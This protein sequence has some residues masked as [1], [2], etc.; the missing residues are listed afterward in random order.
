MKAVIAVLAMAFGGGGAL[1]GEAPSRV[2]GE[3]L[4]QPG[5]LP[6]GDRFVL[7]YGGAN[8]YGFNSVVV[9]GDRA[10]DAVVVLTNAGGNRAE[11]LARRI[12]PFVFRGAK[13]SPPVHNFRGDSHVR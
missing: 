8:D 9:E 4:A 5:R 7:G 3:I 1:A 13:V 11:R 2:G 6:G 10:R 12:A